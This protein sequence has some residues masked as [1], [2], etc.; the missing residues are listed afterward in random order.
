[1]LCSAKKVPKQKKNESSNEKHINRS[2]FQPAMPRTSF[3]GHNCANGLLMLA[4]VELLLCVLSSR[5]VCVA[6]CALLQLG[7]KITISLEDE[8]MGTGQSK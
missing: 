8:P 1:M 3:P 4:L 7:I 5:L 6:V 2:R